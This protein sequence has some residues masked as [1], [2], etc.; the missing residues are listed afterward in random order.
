MNLIKP[1]KLK[2][3]DT[4][5][6]VATSGNLKDEEAL[7]RAISFFETRGFK[8]VLAKNVH[9]Q[10]RYLAG[11]DN[12][13]L[14]ELTQLFL[15]PEI[16]TIIAL[17]GGYGVIRLVEKIDYDLIRKNPKNFVGF[18]DI[19]AL[20]AMFLKKAGLITYSGPMCCG[21]FGL[22]TLNENTVNNFFEVLMNDN[23]LVYEP[24]E[25]CIYREGNAKGITFGG[26]LATVTSLCGIDFIPDED[27]IFFVEDL[28]EPVYKIDKMMHQLI[29]ISKFRKNIKGIII[30]EFLD[31]DNEEWFR[32]VIREVG[33]VLNVPILGN[34][35]ITHNKE[36][37]T[38]PYGAR[39]EIKDN[40][41]IIEN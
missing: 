6:I 38:V 13:K 34:F 39:A 9:D 4:I 18:S 21:D 37:I 20:S 10:K 25:M 2:K 17:R 7:N 26:N 16:T 23:K 19:S 29:N 12:V 27:F 36:K 22:E 33:D 40:K 8:V 15:N 41:F 28:N 11:D 31:V 30:G 14:E 32:D 1:K 5:G 35:R 3:G 24:F